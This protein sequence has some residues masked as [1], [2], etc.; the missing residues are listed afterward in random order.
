MTASTCTARTV[1][2]ET[3]RGPDGA[4][5]TSESWRPLVLLLRLHARSLDDVA[6][7]LAQGRRRATGGSRRGSGARRRRVG[8]VERAEDGLEVARRL[9]G[10]A[11]E[12]VAALL[13]CLPGAAV[14]LHLRRLRSGIDVEPLLHE[15]AA[16]GGQ[17]PGEDPQALL[18]RDP[19]QRV[20]VRDRHV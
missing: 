5:R 16:G 13:G 7:D 6:V 2:A 14:E 20:R 12:G 1:A 9:A 3:T 18:R 17:F 4:P 10:L 11:R 8:D 15:R 19:L